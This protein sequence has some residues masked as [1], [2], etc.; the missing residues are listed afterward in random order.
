MVPQVSF[1]ICIHFIILLGSYH[2]HFQDE[3]QYIY[4]TP[5]NLVV[6]FILFDSNLDG[7]SLVTMNSHCI[8][9]HMNY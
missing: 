7:P 1:L 9:K 2:M 6:I 8:Q 4:M 3:L 5:V